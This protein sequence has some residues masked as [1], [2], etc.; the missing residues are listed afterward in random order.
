[1]F[2][3]IVALYCITDDLL[4]A[5]GH[6]DDCRC[7]V[8]DAELITTAF[9]AALY[10]GGNLET[11]R[12]FM[13]QTGLMP[14]MVSRSRFC[15]RLHRV[16]DLT[17]S[18]FHQLGLILK[19][20]DTKTE[21]LLDSFPVAVCDNIRISRCRIVQ[22]EQFRGKCVAKRRYFYGV[23][24]QVLTTASGIPVEFAFLP[25]RASDTRGLDVLPLE[26]RAGSEVFM[27]S[28]YTDYAAED[29]ARE[30]DGV[31]FSVCRK[32]NSKRR[33]EPMLEYYKVMMRKRIETSFS[34][35]T[36]LF[37]RHLHTVTFRGFLMKI[38]FFIFAFTLERAFI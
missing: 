14:R 12:I 7:Q 15:R 35:I 33:Q 10:F 20:A 5:T 29:A 32:K 34:Q 38:S 9:T 21:Y 2:D 17:Y 27:D 3:N 37:P 8:T 4:K 36:S 31:V 6:T 24:V 1:M 25:G 13:K 19:Q 30:A 11:S 22:G 28:G 16:A 26:L 23:K 18:L